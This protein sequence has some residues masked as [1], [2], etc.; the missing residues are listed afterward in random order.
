[1][2]TANQKFFRQAALE[3][4]IMIS[5]KIKTGIRR[6]VSSFCI[7]GKWYPI[8]GLVFA[9]VLEHV[10]PTAI[11]A[12]CGVAWHSNERLALMEKYMDRTQGVVTERDASFECHDSGQRFVT[13]VPKGTRLFFRAA[14]DIRS[15]AEAWMIRPGK[16]YGLPKK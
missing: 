14:G 16:A 2:A 8:E 3:N 7:D 1:M 15:A 5:G 11:T 6:D 4:E 12:A 9:D 13:K 10:G